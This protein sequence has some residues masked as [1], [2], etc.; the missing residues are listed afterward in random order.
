M[1]KSYKNIFKFIF[2]INITFV[3]TKNNLKTKGAKR[4]NYASS[5]QNEDAVVWSQR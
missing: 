3:H 2:S 5:K 1:A 4:Y